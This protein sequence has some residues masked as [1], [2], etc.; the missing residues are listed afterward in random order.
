MSIAQQLEERRSEAERILLRFLP[1]EDGSPLTSALRYSF[2]AGGKRLRPVLMRESWLLFGGE[3]E[4]IGPF[5]AALEMIHTASLM[6]DDLPAIDNDDYRRGK[7]T[8]HVVYGEAVGLL[9]GDAMLNLAYETLFDTLERPS[10][11]AAEAARIL[12]RK[13]GLLGML[14][15]QGMDV[16]NE[17]RGRPVKDTEELFRI[18]EKKTCALFEA[19]LMC[20][21]VLAGAGREEIAKMEQVGRCLGLAFQIRDDILDVTSTT[22]KLGKPVLSDEKSG[23][24]T[25]VTLMGLEGASARVQDLTCEAVGILESL[26]GETSFLKALFLKIA[27]RDS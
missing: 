8:A 10:F 20:G 4:D 7:K 1:E 26:P 27:G 15:G 14:G 11:V 2:L 25:S 5:M 9:A 6:H 18:F 3:G 17:K 22:E 23:K 13:S 21:A 12:A 19:A 24:V 16:V